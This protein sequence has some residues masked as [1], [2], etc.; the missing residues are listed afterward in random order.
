MY[1]LCMYV[2]TAFQIHS[3][4]CCAG[5]GK[6]PIVGANEAVGKLIQIYVAVIQLLLHKETT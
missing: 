6:A 3:P 2:I 1:N 4:L 5:D